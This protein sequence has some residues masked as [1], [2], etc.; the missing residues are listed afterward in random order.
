MVWVREARGLKSVVWVCP[1]AWRLAA[2]AFGV[3]LEVWGV[4][5][6]VELAFESLRLRSGLHE[7]CVAYAWNRKCVYRPSSAQLRFQY[8]TWA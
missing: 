1:I 8:P 2:S 5:V 7:L 4:V 6:G 3:T